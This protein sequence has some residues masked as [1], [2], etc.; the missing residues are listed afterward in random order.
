[1]AVFQKII[2]SSY[3]VSAASPCFMNAALQTTRSGDN[4]ALLSPRMPAAV[5]T[6]GDRTPGSQDCRFTAQCVLPAHSQ[7]GSPAALSPCSHAALC[8]IRAVPFPSGFSP[9]SKLRAFL[10]EWIFRNRWGGKFGDILWKL[11]FLIE[12][13]LKTPRGSRNWS[14]GSR[15]GSGKLRFSSTKSRGALRELAWTRPWCA[16]DTHTRVIALSYAQQFRA[17][18]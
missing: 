17:R 9:L 1:M 7:P 4:H 10:L 15:P 14:R 16:T 18:N 13:T 12:Q 8:P 5:T 2:L 3:S 11:D 6:K